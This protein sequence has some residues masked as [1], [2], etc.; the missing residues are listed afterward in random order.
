MVNYS[1]TNAEAKILFF[2]N[3]DK[4]YN[5]DYVW[6]KTIGMHVDSRNSFGTMCQLYK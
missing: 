3:I 1:Y 5:I 6:F 4:Y 2:K